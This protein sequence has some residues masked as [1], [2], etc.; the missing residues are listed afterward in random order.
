ME[1]LQAARSRVRGTGVTVLRGCS[2][3]QGQKKRDMAKG[4][5]LKVHLGL[6]VLRMMPE[7]PSREHITGKHRQDDHKTA[8]L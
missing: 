4:T 5:V 1:G 7:S 2:A 8:S 3:P 6:V